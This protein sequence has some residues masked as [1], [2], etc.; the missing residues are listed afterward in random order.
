MLDDAQRRAERAML[1]VGRLQG[2]LE[3]QQRLLEDRDQRSAQAEAERDQLRA[4]R[5]QLRAER[6]RLHLQLE[7]PGSELKQSDPDPERRPWWRR[8]LRRR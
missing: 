3:A 5:D 1:E 4:E 8:W 6:D 7:Y 2:Q